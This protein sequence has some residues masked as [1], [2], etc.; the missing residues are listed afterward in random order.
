[1]P[2][3]HT[4]LIANR[5][6]IACRIAKTAKRLG[7][8]TVAVFSDADR[9]AR[10][11]RLCDDAYPLGGE[12]PA[13]SYLRP[14][15]ILA[16]A[17]AY[18]AQAIHPGYGFLSENP[19][20][21]EACQAAGLILIGPSPAAMRAM[22]DKSAAKTTMAQAGV[23]LVPGYHGAV[24]D[25]DLLAREAAQIGYPVLI[26]ASAGGGGKG[27]RIVDNAA[28]FAAALA[29]CQR[30]AKNAF[31]N[32]KVLI[33]KYIVKPR[34]IEIQVFADQQGNAVYLFE[35]DCSLQR[36]HQKVL[37]EAPA[38][39]LSEPIRQAMGQAAVAAAKAVNYVGA[40]TVEFIYAPSGEFYFMEM[41]TRLQVEH[42]VTEMITGLDLV[43]WQFRVAAGEPLPRQQ[44][45]L[46]IRGHA[47]EARLYAEQPEHD[48]LPSIGHLTY[49][50][51]PS[52]AV[53]GLAVGEFTHHYALR[54]DSGVQAGNDITPLYDPMIAKLIAWGETREMALA[55]LAVLLKHTH[56]VGVQTN[57]RFLRRV[58]AH[59]AFIQ[60]ELDTGFIARHAADLLSLPV[61]TTVHGLLATIA[62]LTH[63][64]SAESAVNALQTAS[65]SPYAAK[66]AWRIQG[67]AW[68]SLQFASVQKGNNDGPVIQVDY[69]AP[70][71][72]WQHPAIAG[73]PQ[74]AVAG[75][76]HAVHYQT[77]PLYGATHTDPAG[78]EIQLQ[79]GEIAVTA[80]LFVTATGWKINLAGNPEQD[81]VTLRYLDP[82][83]VQAGAEAGHA[84]EQNLRAPM[85][86]KVV[87]L[88]AAIGQPV[89]AGAPLLVLEAM[90]MEH[91]LRAATAGQVDEWLCA[92]GE[93]VADGAQL[94][95][96]SAA[97]TSPVN[98]HT[99]LAEEA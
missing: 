61:A 72:A 47:I 88:L 26:K 33:E 36:R 8:R 64:A 30:E 58:I 53:C 7:L 46:A 94:L 90:K 18:G 77:Q 51:L 40:G 21:A 11:V 69:L 20:F 15:K 13:D 86:G 50:Q 10:H 12:S 19:D 67:P 73:L 17:R 91:T 98:E 97:A 60:A 71:P 66:T 76:S 70:A 23:P 45:Q 44:A 32:D 29:S 31:G 81:G 57:A 16:A 5:G 89:A 83:A 37:E 25:P 84:G 41:N 54:V 56:V 87:A 75:V 80:Q 99:P 74:M 28:D 1:M 43:E 68:R 63:E 79:W 48:F 24:Q 4:V 2:T 39:H 22:G 27:M 55:N 59:P 85:P 14:E 92:V 78:W 65:R 49:C 6:E 62:Q 96:F 82:R 35:R 9:Q 34:H 42:P 38:P 93:Q 3:F 95:R 52:T